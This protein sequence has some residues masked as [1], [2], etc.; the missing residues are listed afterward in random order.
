MAIHHF[1]A[2]DLVVARGW[3]PIATFP[4]DG[5]VV[6]LRDEAGNI[7][8]ASWREGQ[9]WMAKGL[10]GPPTQWRHPE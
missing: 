1:T 9:I 8:Q 7:D 2:P 4:Q 10:A 6:E 3:Q 5:S